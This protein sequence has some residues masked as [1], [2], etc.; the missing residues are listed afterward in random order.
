MLFLICRV[1][2]GLY[3]L[4]RLHSSSYHVFNRKNPHKKIRRTVGDREDREER[5]NM[6]IEEYGETEW[7]CGRNNMGFAHQPRSAFQ[8]RC[9]R[10]QTFASQH[11]TMQY[12]DHI[13]EIV[14]NIPF[15]KNSNYKS[16]YILFF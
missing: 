11:I 14:C 1:G 6:G 5:M 7:W 8:A 10:Q 16:E 15:G 9:R 13:Y 2:I 3:F 12:S 4:C